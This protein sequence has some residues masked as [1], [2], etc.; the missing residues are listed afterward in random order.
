VPKVA[1]PTGVDTNVTGKGKRKRKAKKIGVATLFVV[2]LILILFLGRSA[3]HRDRSPFGKT[4]QQV[5]R[6]Y[7]EPVK[8]DGIERTYLLGDIIARVDFFHYEGMSRAMYVF[9]HKD[10]PVP[11]VPNR[12]TMQEAQHLM[13]EASGGGQWKFEQNDSKHSS[14]DA[15]EYVYREKSLRLIHRR[16]RYV[17]VKDLSAT[18]YENGDF[19]F[20][21]DHGSDAFGTEGL[22]KPASSSAVGSL[23]QKQRQTNAKLQALGLD[24]IN[25][26]QSESDRLAALNAPET[27]TPAVD[28]KPAA[29]DIKGGFREYRLGMKRADV[30]GDLTKEHSFTEDA[31]EYAVASFD[32]ALG[33]F[34]IDN[35]KLEF[36]RSLG[37]LKK[38]SVWIKGE[39]NVAGV[40]E[41]FKVAYG[42][43]EKGGL[44]ND[45]YSWRGT[46]IELRYSVDVMFDTTATATWTSKKV[47]KLIEDDRTRRAKEGAP[48][49]AKG[50]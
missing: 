37:I 47:E 48:N 17:Y 30:P 46:D 36:D 42:E 31:E 3:T 44:G 22:S 20:I 10:S 15:I 13:R 29:L 41:A 27:K 7:G 25:T 43:P 16:L 21:I 35:I 39:Q 40:L 18:Y 9:F 33:A 24:T 4:E 38:V 32:H 14:H 45:V 2:G 5:D 11:L 49:A 23:R 6:L 12:I 19:L 1:T 28:E 34:Q 8:T 26:T 50:L